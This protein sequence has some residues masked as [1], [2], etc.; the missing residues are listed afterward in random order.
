MDTWN[1]QQYERFRAE[2]TQPLLDLI[3][4]VQ[5]RPGMRVLDLG[6]GTGEGTRQLH[7]QLAAKET[8]GLDSSAAM[9]AKAAPLAGQGLRFEQGEIERLDPGSRWDLI[10][11]NAA[12][13]WVSDHGELLPRLASLLDAGGQ[14][15]V[16]MPANHLHQSHR[17]AYDLADES[18][19][20][21][22]LNGWRREVPVLVPEAYA[23]L[24]HALGF[25]RQHVRLEVYGHELRSRAEVVEWVKGSLLTDYQS[26]LPPAL[27]EE[28]LARYQARL[29][30]LLENAVPFFYT[31]PRLFLW[32][33][34]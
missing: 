8:V 21:E 28:F 27:Y 11:S 31:Y 23:T 29:L 1:P 12:L 24:L 22:A 14:L 3:S 20:V 18:P 25:R 32:G 30:P 16:Q 7:E 9:L 19:F 15:A 34:K 13:H 33:Q 10:F 6:C 5:R 26:R 17:T 4:L 2:R